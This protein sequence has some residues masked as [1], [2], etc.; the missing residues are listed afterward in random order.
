MTRPRAGFVWVKCN[1]TVFTSVAV[2]A[3]PNAIIDEFEQFLNRLV[4]DARG[5]S[6]LVIAGDFNAW[7]VEWG[8][9]Y[10]NERGRTVLAFL[11]LPN[12]ELANTGDMHLPR[13]GVVCYGSDVHESDNPLRIGVSWRVSEYYTHSDHQALLYVV[14]NQRGMILHQNINQLGG[15]QKRLTKCSDNVWRR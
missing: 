10:T 6:P 5:R 13:R 9:S 7:A 8:S 1:V 14:K 3:S 15:K 2:Y 4:Y 12:V 11:S